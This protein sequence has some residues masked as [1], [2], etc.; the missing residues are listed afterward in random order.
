MRFRAAEVLLKG[1]RP[2]PERMFLPGLGRPPP[3]RGPLALVG[4]R[5]DDFP[6]CR[7]RH[8]SRETDLPDEP[9]PADFV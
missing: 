8:D 1:P 2:P 6:N 4:C 5:L 9:V 7:D 3:S